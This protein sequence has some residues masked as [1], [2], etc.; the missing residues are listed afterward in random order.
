[1]ADNALNNEQTTASIP[2][3]EAEIG[4][5]NY[6]Q[7]LTLSLLGSEKDALEQIEAA[8]ERIGTGSFGRCAECGVKIPEARLEAIPY[9]ALCIRCAS[10]REQG[11]GP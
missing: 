7:Q 2:T 4:S 6:D 8:I 11:H 1:M 10:Q 3:D 9:A 5:G